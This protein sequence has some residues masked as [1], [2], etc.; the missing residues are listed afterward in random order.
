MST[1]A[2][3]VF[4]RCA[5]F[6]LRVPAIGHP[7][8]PATLRSGFALVLTVAVLPAV[9]AV[10]PLDGLALL[11]AFGFEFLVGMALGM[12]A[13]IVYDAAY[14]GGRI[15][16]DY[17]GVRAIAPS[18][19][20]VAPSGYGRIWSLA[21]TGAFLFAGAYRPVVLT[22]AHAFTVLPP[23]APLLGSAWMA[24]ALAAVRTMLAVAASVA[25]P[26]VALAFVV[27]V[28]LG[29]LARAVP[30]FGSLTL[31][32]PLVF[33]A[34]LVATALALAPLLALAAHPLLLLPA[35]R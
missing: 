16:D 30:R 23:E 21:F 7:S 2:L 1:T 33:G 24:F 26:A 12:S 13:A 22:F 9:R 5:G 35:V 19:A 14:A 20:L 8:V 11:T 10:A 29:A 27:H 34:A 28:A 32:Y 15:V 3:L 18:V 25:A 6:A 4:A 31:A 17:I